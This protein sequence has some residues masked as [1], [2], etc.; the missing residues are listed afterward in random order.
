MKT[1]AIAFLAENKSRKA[2]YDIFAMG[3][4]LYKMH[5]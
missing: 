1:F 3:V 4:C 5:R 2:T